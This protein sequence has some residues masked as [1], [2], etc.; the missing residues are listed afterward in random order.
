MMNQIDAFLNKDNAFAVVGVSRNP[1]KYGY[2]IY[3]DLKQKGY[4]VYPINPN[5]KMINDDP[6]Y[7]SLSELPVKP[8]V[9]DIVVPPE[10][11]LE[12]VKECY[13]LGIRKVWFQPGAESDETIDYCYEHDIEV[14][15]G[16]CIM[17]ES[18][19]LE[20]SADINDTINMS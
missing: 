4:K 12:V 17:V 14:I 7:A 16:A 9:V 10:V 5:A 19:N 15:Y 13:E 20:R 1:S 6:V 11:A 8:D 18:S 3:Y 2:I